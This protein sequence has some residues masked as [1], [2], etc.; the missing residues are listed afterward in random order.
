MLA[1]ETLSKLRMG[2]AMLKRRVRYTQSGPGDA[3]GFKNDK[4]TYCYRKL[5]VTFVLFIVCRCN[6][7]S[8]HNGSSVVSVPAGCAQYTPTILFFSWE[9]LWKCHGSG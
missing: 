5:D 4:A 7:T 3:G 6:C 2:G 8:I 9:L 1:R